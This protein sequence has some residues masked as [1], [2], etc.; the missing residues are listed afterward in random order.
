MG[1]YAETSKKTSGFVE[2]L[3]AFVARI[4]DKELDAI[5]QRKFQALMGSKLRWT[6]SNERSKG[7]EYEKRF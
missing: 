4:L 3:Y 5:V 1:K 6:P 2:W 7:F